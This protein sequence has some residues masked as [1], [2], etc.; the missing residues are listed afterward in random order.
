MAKQILQDL[1]FNN[2]AR[3]TNLPVASGSGEPVTFEQLNSA[4]EGMSWK[5][6]VVVATQGDLNLASPGATID[7]VTM[8]ASDRVLVRNQAAPAQN[9]IY[10]WNGA[11]A[12]MTRADDASTAEELESATTTVDE[13]TDAGTTWRQSA[14]NFVLDTDGVVWVSFGAGVPAA[15]ETVAGKVELANQSEVDAGTDTERA[16]TPA[17]LASWSGR[18]RKASAAFGDGTA[19][20]FDISHN[21]S[22]RDVAVSVYRN[23]TPWDDIL[24]DVQRPD[25]NTVRL[26]FAAAPTLNQFRYV[27]EG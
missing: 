25:T 4:V 12:A 18:L 1:D 10:V 19:T 11:A 7:G 15:S 9:G 17:T 23:G 22:T 16:V 24:C 6:N 26:I 5:D 14:V 3:I 2:V 8:S 13:G 27:I 21:W 20:Q